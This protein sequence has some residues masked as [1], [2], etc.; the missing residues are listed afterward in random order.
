[1]KDF[2]MKFDHFGHD[3]KLSPI[4][5]ETHKTFIGGVVSVALV[6]VIMI[7][8]FIVVANRMIG[9]SGDKFQ[10]LDSP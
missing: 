1:M 9:H 6:N 4:E 2:I 7:L 3:I 10:S 8:Y 5:K